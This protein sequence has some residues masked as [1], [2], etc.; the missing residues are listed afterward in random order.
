[1]SYL[2]VTSGMI[3]TVVNNWGRNVGSINA[4]LLLSLVARIIMTLGNREATTSI[5]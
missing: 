2:S 4:K 5:V 3:I 1:M